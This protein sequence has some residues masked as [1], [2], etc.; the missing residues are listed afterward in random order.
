MGKRD[1]GQHGNERKIA[2]DGDSDIEIK[3]VSEERN[4]HTEL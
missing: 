3:R 4:V 1:E 2:N